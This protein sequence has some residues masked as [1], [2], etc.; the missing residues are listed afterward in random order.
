MTDTSEQAPPQSPVQR[1]RAAHSKRCPIFGHG[2]DSSRTRRVDCH[3]DQCT[4]PSCVTYK[5]CDHPWHDI[6][7]ALIE[8]GCP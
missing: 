6:H 4:N 5:E 1:I 8:L 7:E 3:D 2:N